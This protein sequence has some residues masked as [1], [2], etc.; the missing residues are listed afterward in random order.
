MDHPRHI[1]M[2]RRLLDNIAA[3]RLEMGDREYRI[4]VSA[5]TCPDAFA[6]EYRSLFRRYPLVLGHGDQLRNP[7]DCMTH[8]QLGVPILL[9][10]AEDGRL[11]GFLNQCAHRA[12]RLL[13]AAEPSQV[14]KLVCPYHNWVYGLDGRLERIPHHD[15]AFPHTQLAE[16]GLIE[17]P[18]AEEGG[19]I[20]VLPTPGEP[21]D[22][23]AWMG[24]M[25]EDLEIFRVQDFV[26]FRQTVTERRCNWKLV[27]DA[28]QESYHVRRLHKDT[29]GPFFLDGHAII[30]QDEVHMIASVARKTIAEATELPE[31]EWDD[32]HHTSHSMY[33]LP[34]TV[35]VCHPDYTSLMHM[36]PQA[37]DRTIIVHNMLIP[38]DPATDKARR[39]WERSFDLIDGG[40]F[41]A[42]DYATAERMH[43]G[44]C[45]GGRDHLLI[46]RNEYSIITFHETLERLIEQRP[47]VEKTANA[48]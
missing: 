39:H 9:T 4:P 21:F 40:V 31:S 44:L 1:R 16:R 29:V 47:G 19:L 28:F 38:E 32:R 35:I 37:A 46:G 41:N 24:P 5:Y 7:G 20:W 13:D 22:A 2:F 27:M 48:S 8:D 23:Q 30:D 11:R 12:T 43:Q 34:N 10:R 3:D 14:R 18:C 42:E 36:Y 26:F 17:L 45:E 6:R 25:R 15:E 33:F